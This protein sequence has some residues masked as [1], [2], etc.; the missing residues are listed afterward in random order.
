MN[1]IL[2]DLFLGDRHDAENLPSLRAHQITH[3]VN[4]AQ[5]LRCP[6]PDD[7][8]Y[9]S[10]E[11]EDPDECFAQSAKISNRFID[12]ARGKGNILVHCRKGLS[13]SPSI[14]MAY[15]GHMGFRFDQA[16]EH[17]LTRADISPHSF[18]LRELQRMLRPSDH[19]KRAE[20]WINKI[21][22]DLWWR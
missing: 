12:A 4:C 14:I 18:F 11:M 3:V 8:L 5:G 13:R 10:L 6:F 7:F 17:M 21:A 16:L 9:L 22:K 19:P 1:R 15:L 20:K 2:F